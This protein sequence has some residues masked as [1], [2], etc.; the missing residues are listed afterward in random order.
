MWLKGYLL[1]AAKPVL[2]GTR[3]VDPRLAAL[4]AMRGAK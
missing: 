4:E 3:G 2:G 1:K